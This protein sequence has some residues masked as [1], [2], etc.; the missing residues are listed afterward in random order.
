MQSQ[1]AKNTAIYA[2]GDIIPKLLNLITIP[3][4]TTHLSTEDFGIVNYVNSIEMF[5]SILTLMGLKTYFLVYYYR[6][7]DEE[8]QKRLLGSLTILVLFFN[9]LLCTIL[10]VIGP[11]FF[12]KIGQNINFYP[13]I[14]L[15]IANNFLSTFSTLP[16]ALYRVRENPLPL[17]VINALKG[18][19]IL[20]G[21]II[22]IRHTPNAEVVLRVKILVSAVF[23]VYFG[24]IAIR[25]SIFKIDFSLFKQALLFSLPLVPGDIAYYFSTM[26]DRILIER[27]LS[28]S[29]LGIYSLAATLAGLLNIISYGAYKAFE[30]FFFKT[31]G[32]ITFV[33]NFEKVRNI[34]LYI[35]LVFGLCLSI[36]SK[37]V[38]VL[39][40]KPE[41]IDASNYVAPLVL[42]VMIS[43][44]ATMYGTV[45]T[46]QSKTKLNGVISLITAV[47]SVVFNMIFLPI[48]GI[49]AATIANVL[50][51]SLSLFLSRTISNIRIETLR[52]M[53]GIVFFI[54]VSYLAN[55]HIGFNNVIQSVLLKVLIVSLFSTVLANI[56]KV[57][58]RNI[59]LMFKKNQ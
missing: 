49:W 32:Q 27:Y 6:A 59:F 47:V 13:F 8:K 52:P 22:I 33:H 25:N 45:L 31:Y 29:V 7:G 21:T 11:I 23:A 34:L 17:T 46:A 12:N 44:I 58:P 57:K 1:L 55:Y 48:I 51:F 56:F 24:I 35:M 43:S 9:L 40:A 4:L 20:L 5:L 18:L 42:G 39:F 10:M 16:S 26:S 14:F 36:F 15:G 50:I 37:E 2:L 30:P 28:A 3:I 41:Y 38:V 19:L 54:L 53:L